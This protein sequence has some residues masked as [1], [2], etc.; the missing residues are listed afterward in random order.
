MTG[1]G[2]DHQP[3]DE[4]AAA[5]A[6]H[7]LEPAD[8]ERFLRHAADCPRC[9]R[10]MTGFR[11]VAAALA[12][13]APPAEPSQRLGERIRA[14]A[15]AGPGQ[16]KAP[17]ARSVAGKP[18]AGRESAAAPAGP[19][20]RRVTA[21]RRHPGHR[22]HRARRRRRTAL[23]AVAAVLIAA[24]GTWAGLAATGGAPRPPS[25]ACVHAGSCAQ[26]VLTSSATHRTVAK[27]IVSGGVA[28][29]EPAAVAANPSDEIYVLWQI[30]GAHTPLAVG[31]FDIRP[32]ARHVIRL[33]ALAAPYGRTWAFAVSLERGRTIPVSPSHPIALGQVA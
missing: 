23:A 22:D 11:D 24:G 26:V 13:T 3:Y 21:L 19:S 28:W 9:L 17:G 2:S 27:V 14:A 32:G 15:L 29:L 8:E 12:E 18:A 10:S 7:A 31:S 25:A 20:R 1:P 4:L 5:H 6:L 33:G 16:Q 30:T